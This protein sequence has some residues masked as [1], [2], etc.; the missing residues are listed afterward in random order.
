MEADTM[1]R[2]SAVRLS[3]DTK[4]SGDVSE[5]GLLLQLHRTT[6]DKLAENLG[7]N[8]DSSARELTRFLTY[9]DLLQN[10]PKCERDSCGGEFR[11]TKLANCADRYHWRCADCHRVKKTTRFL[12]FQIKT[13]FARHP[14][15]GPLLG[16]EPHH[17]PGNSAPR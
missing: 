8:D 7:N 17:P 10:Q 12:F 15:H 2:E 13:S 5:V 6:S 9:H 16:D 4:L 3:A 14:I 11:L 1:P